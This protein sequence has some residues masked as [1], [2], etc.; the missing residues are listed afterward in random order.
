[1]RL[2][3][4]L[5]AL[6]LAGALSG[7]ATNS[8]I[9]ESYKVPYSNANGGDAEPTTLETLLQAA[10]DSVATNGLLDDNYVAELEKITYVIVEKKEGMEGIDRG[11]QLFGDYSSS[12]KVR[13][14][15]KENKP[16]V[17]ADI[18]HITY[19]EL[20]HHFWEK[21]LSKK[22]RNEFRK[23]VLALR[24]QYNKLSQLAGDNNIQE[25]HEEICKQFG[26][27]QET[28]HNFDFFMRREYLYREY[29][30]KDFERDFFGK[31]AHAYLA[32]SELIFKKMAKEKLAEWDNPW[33]QM[34]LPRKEILQKELVQ[35]RHIPKNV[36][37]FYR[38]FLNS[39]YFEA[40]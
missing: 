25:I 35:L 5:G 11:P 14:F 28:Y 39:R 24:E 17:K 23:G 13:V 29:Y 33:V 1:M 16:S 10:I 8:A 6:A 20:A 2:N 26:F 3:N 4:L 34:V 9:I 18:I 7:C 37:K 15:I 22:Q 40:K 30:G 31:E 32:Q 21:F 36:R 27:T 19:H 12:R 38:G